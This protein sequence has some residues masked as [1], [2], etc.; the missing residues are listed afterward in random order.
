[1]NR[2][3]FLSEVALN[4]FVVL[5]EPNVRIY[6]EIR[7]VSMANVCISRG[8]VVLREA[9]VSI[10]RE[11]RIVAQRPKPIQIP[12]DSENSENSETPEDH[13]EIFIY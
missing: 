4:R 7:M 1:M 10:P 5:R 8:I 12:E 9:N 2:F 3:I 6:R 11:I 13:T